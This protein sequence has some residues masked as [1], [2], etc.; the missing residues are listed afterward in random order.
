M[1][2]A[3]VHHFS[4]HKLFPIVSFDSLLHCPEL[5]QFECQ[6]C[7]FR[8]IEFIQSPEWKRVY[9][10]QRKLLPARMMF[11]TTS[12]CDSVLDASKSHLLLIKT[13]CQLNKQGLE[14]RCIG[15]NFWPGTGGKPVELPN[16]GRVERVTTSELMDEKNMLGD[17][18]DSVL[19]IILTKEDKWP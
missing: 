1:Q 4:A 18:R 5:H 9:Q 7:V 19:L 17:L 16:L 14:N 8:D 3:I 10:R 6:F 15:K 11:Q 2:H 12:Q 13:P